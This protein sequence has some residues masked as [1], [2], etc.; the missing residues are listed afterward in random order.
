[1]ATAHT[2]DGG[3]RLLT[4]AEVAERFRVAPCTV[5]KWV[6]GKRLTSLR[7]LG[8]HLRFHPAEIA[9]L[10]SDTDQAAQQ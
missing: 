4:S 7:T 10:L 9:A 5:R 3:E 6:K 8:G 2:D 1:M